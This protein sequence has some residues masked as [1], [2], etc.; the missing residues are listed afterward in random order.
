MPSWWAACVCPSSWASLAPPTFPAHSLL[1]RGLPGNIFLVNVYI[2]GDSWFICGQSIPGETHRAQPISR[3]G[4]PLPQQLLVGSSA[5]GPSPS[6]LDYAGFLSPRSGTGKVPRQ[7]A[8]TGSVSPTLMQAG[9]PGL[10]STRAEAS[11][12]RAQ[13]LSTERGAAGTQGR[14]TGAGG[15][16]SAR[17]KHLTP[18]CHPPAG[19]CSLRPPQGPM[20]PLLQCRKGSGQRSRSVAQGPGHGPGHPYGGLSLP[21]TACTILVAARHGGQWWPLMCMLAK[22]R[23]T[24]MPGCVTVCGRIWGDELCA[25][26]GTQESAVP[27]H[28]VC[29]CACVSMCPGVW[30][31][32]PGAQGW[33]MCPLP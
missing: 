28:C 7:K 27:G 11:K 31:E 26:R 16:P 29:A 13:Y 20:L 17:R 5:L 1:P 21:T 18:S 25:S 10:V 12:A 19:G 15:W 24:P 3:R 9:R 33:G 4:W 32:C 6:L 22:E 23:S 14:N 8:S 2:F 30:H